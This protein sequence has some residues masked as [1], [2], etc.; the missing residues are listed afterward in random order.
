VGENVDAIATKQDLIGYTTAAWGALVAYVDGLPAD[1]WTGPKDAAGWSVQDHV[2]HVTHWD[3][4]VIEALRNNVPMPETLGISD[5]AWAAESFDPMNEEIRR[6]A[7]SDSVHQLKA[8]RDATWAD[9]VSLMGELSEEQLA[10]SGAEAGLAIGPRPLAEPL[11]QVL[12]DYCG[13]HYA[14]HLRDIKAIVAGDPAT[15]TR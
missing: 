8:E 3:R 12:V 15:K 10:R 9:L 5:T 6:R 14:E 13:N 2:A 4:A 11:L 7:P 1:Q